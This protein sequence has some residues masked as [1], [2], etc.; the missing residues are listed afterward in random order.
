MAWRQQIEQRLQRLEGHHEDRPWEKD[1]EEDRFASNTSHGML[2]GNM[3]PDIIRINGVDVFTPALDDDGNLIVWDETTDPPTNYPAQRVG[4]TSTTAAHHGF[5]SN[6][7]DDLGWLMQAGMGMEGL[8]LPCAIEFAQYNPKGIGY[9]FQDEGGERPGLKQGRYS[10]FEQPNTKLMD[11]EGDPG[12]GDIDET[13][14]KPITSASLNPFVQKHHV[15]S[16][17][18]GS[19]RTNIRISNEGAGYGDGTPLLGGVPPTVGESQRP[20]GL[21]GPLIMTGWGYDTEDLPVPNKKLEAGEK[22]SSAKSENFG[23]PKNL[24]EKLERTH[25]KIHFLNDHLRRVDRWKSGP[26]D[27]RWDRE[28]KVW[29]A[30]GRNR[31][32]L[33][34]AT[35]CIVPQVGPD[36]KNS[37]NWGVGGTTASPGRQYRNPCPETDC[38]Y[39]SYFPTSKYYPDIEIYDPEDQEWCGKCRVKLLGAK[40]TPI[41]QCDEFG[42]ACVPFYDAIILKSVEHITSG[43]V[44]SDC[45][46]KYKRTGAGP[47][48]RRVGDP[49]HNWGSSYTSTEEYLGDIMHSASS[50][51]PRPI[52]KQQTPTYSETA[53]S[54]LHRRIFVENPLSQGLMLGDAFLSYDTGRRVAHT[55]QRRKDKGGCGAEGEAITVTEMLP[56]HVIL[57]AEF[58]G[59][60][61]VGSVACQQGEM[62]ACTRKIFAQGLTTSIDCG[63]DDDYPETAIY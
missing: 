27:L 45:G 4:S 58:F 36:G 42:D 9:E 3:I 39:G 50:S 30:N 53:A 49:C 29:V 20:M 38:T 51:Q 22:E 62:G 63:P 61:F 28:R 18:R 7:G 60:E 1:K 56:V 46:D 17:L 57:Q 26:V 47:E 34:K 43:K 40:R 31:V 6:V 21:R 37:W 10:V 52:G 54:I 23:L 33:S 55:Y 16:L 25:A 35:K 14:S 41:V 48:D 44:K 12:T 32:Y 2:A 59:V 5:K 19:K 8:L 15:D 13:G 24:P 11:W